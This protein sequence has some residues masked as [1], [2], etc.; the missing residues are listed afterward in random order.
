M[1]KRKREKPKV[2][3]ILTPGYQQ[4][5]TKAILE[6]YEEQERKAM[7]KRMIDSID[8]SE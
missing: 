1:G 3:F 7:E 2:E 6:V 4:R 8:T 5:W